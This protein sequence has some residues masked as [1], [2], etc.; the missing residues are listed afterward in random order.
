MNKAY[1]YCRHST[2]LQATSTEIQREEIRRYFDYKLAP[3]GI[4][5]VEPHVDA[6]TSGTVN[7]MDRDAGRKLDHLAERGDHIIV[8]KL[9]R[10]F[11]SARDFLTMHEL[12]ISRGVTLHMLDLQ[13]DSGTPVGKMM[14]GVIA[15]VSEFERSRI[16]ERFI[17]GSKLG[18]KR[19]VE[20]GL[21]DISDGSAPLGFKT[22]GERPNKHWVRDRE[23]RAH[24]KQMLEWYREGA[25]W[26]QIY[27]ALK[28]ARMF[29]RKNRA[30]AREWT[31][32]YDR[33]NDKT[34]KSFVVLWG[35][36]LSNLGKCMIQKAIEA[37]L[38]LQRWE[39]EGKTDP[40]IARTLWL[41]MLARREKRILEKSEKLG[42][43]KVKVTEYIGSH[44][45]D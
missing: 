42:L 31:T 18:K 22:V 44:A 45:Q 23:E 8:S 3:L 20:R 41:E 16:V 4:E 21:P 14:M 38:R 43:A 11:R 6:A 37:E 12:W 9:D 13:I 30:G 25:N 33:W 5:W 34:I 10:G 29:R 35:G 17:A 36:P 7:F 24:M 40:W 19:K 1:P 2:N 27:V 15:L 26:M 39:E 32:S 28:K